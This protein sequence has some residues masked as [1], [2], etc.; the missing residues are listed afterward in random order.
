MRKPL[1]TDYA[2]FQAARN[3]WKVSKKRLKKEGRQSVTNCHRL[4]MEHT[5]GPVQIVR[6]LSDSNMTKISGEN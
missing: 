1:G 4:K 6:T 5:E 3:Y 2:D